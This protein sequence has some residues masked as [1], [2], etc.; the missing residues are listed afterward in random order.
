[1]TTSLDSQEVHVRNLI[2]FISSCLHLPF[3][4]NNFFSNILF[5]NLWPQNTA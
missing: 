2:S 5:L 1:M 4:V 3:F